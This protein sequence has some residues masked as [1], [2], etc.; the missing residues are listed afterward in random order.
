MS[1]SRVLR[2]A[3]PFSLACLAMPA[4]APHAAAQVADSEPPRPRL[5]AGADTNNWTAYYDWGVS[6]LRTSPVQAAH[7]F[8]WAERL[9]PRRAEPIYGRWVAFWMANAGVLPDYLARSPKMLGD[10][11]ILTNDSLYYRALLR[12]PLVNRSLVLLV[13]EQLPGDWRLDPYTSAWIAFANRRYR[14]AANLFAK[15]IRNEPRVRS[16]ARFDRALVLVALSQYD[17]AAAE[18]STLLGDMRRRDEKELVYLYESKELYEYALGMLR[19][20]RGDTAAARAAMERALQENLGFYPAHAGLG[21]LAVMRGDYASAT[22]E[23][24]LAAELAP[25][26][27]LMHFQLGDALLRADRGAEA[28]PHLQHAVELEPWFA[29]PYLELGAALEMAGRPDDAKHAYGTFIA[30][31][32]REAAPQVNAARSRLAALAAGGH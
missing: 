1:A 21:Q 17:S 13:I 32:P 30:R 16:N 14:D 5:E 15:A 10:P 29:D 20:A 12:N 26:D 19:G 18:M 8:R 24:S 25:D 2:L 22:T 3:A 31:A 23:F 11:R 7:A 9:D 6:R 28:V 27:P 4:L